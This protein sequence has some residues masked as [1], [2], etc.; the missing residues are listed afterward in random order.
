MTAETRTEEGAAILEGARL[1]PTTASDTV[2]AT[3]PSTP[4]FARQNT[5][6]SPTQM[7]TP[8]TRNLRGLTLPSPISPST[9][10]STVQPNQFQS[11]GEG[12]ASLVAQAPITPVRPA[13]PNTPLLSNPSTASPLPATSP[14]GK[15]S[16][17]GKLKSLLP[18]SHHQ[19]HSYFHAKVEIEQLASVPFVR[20]EFGVRWKFK[21]SVSPGDIKSDRHTPP[22]DEGSAGGL[23]GKMK[24]RSMTG[25]GKGKEDSHGSGEFGMYQTSSNS[26]SPHLVSEGSRS[27][28]LNSFS[29]Y[30]SADSVPSRTSSTA[31][32]NTGYTTVSTTTNGSNKTVAPNGNL[33]RNF[34]SPR[35][36]EVSP[37]KLGANQYLYSHSEDTEDSALFSP[38]QQQAFSSNAADPLSPGWEG[39][40]SPNVLSPTGTITPANASSHPATHGAVSPRNLAYITPPS[41]SPS[42]GLVPYRP[43]KDHS[44]TYS[45]PLNAIVK[46]DIARSGGSG[47]D[48]K[49]RPNLQASE[50]KLVVIQRVIPD[51][52]DGPPQNPRLGAIYLNL[53]EYVGKGRVERRY[54]LKESRLSIELTYVSGNSEYVAPPLPKAEIMGGIENFLVQNEN[55]NKQRTKD[56]YGYT[57][58]P[59][60][61]KEE[62]EVDLLGQANADLLE[63][64]VPIDAG[65]LKAA[66]SRDPYAIP[67]ESESEMDVQGSEAATTTT[68]IDQ[69]RRMFLK[70]LGKSPTMS[71]DKAQQTKGTVT[72]KEAEKLRRRQIKREE[73]QRRF[74][75]ELD[76]NPYALPPSSG[77]S[78]TESEPEEKEESE[79][80]DGFESAPEDDDGGKVDTASIQHTDESHS[81]AGHSSGHDHQR[82]Y[83]PR[84]TNP[85]VSLA[86]F[87]TFDIQRLPLAYGPKTTEVLIDAIFN[88]TLTTDKSKENPFTLYISPGDLARMKDDERRALMENHGGPARVLARTAAPSMRSNG[89]SYS[90]ATSNSTTTTSDSGRSHETDDHLE[91]LRSPDTIVGQPVRRQSPTGLGLAGVPLNRDRDATIDGTADR[92]PQQGGVGGLLQSFQKH[93]KDKVHEGKKR[94]VPKRSDTKRSGSSAASHSPNSMNVLGSP[95]FVQE[96]AGMDSEDVGYGTLRRSGDSNFSNMRANNSSSASLSSTSHGSRSG[97]GHGAPLPPLPVNASGRATPTSRP[98][99]RQN[100]TAS[101]DLSVPDGRMDRTGFVKGSHGGGSASPVPAPGLGNSFNRWW[102]GLGGAHGSSPGA[103]HHKAAPTAVAS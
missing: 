51:D 43:L 15:A 83:R 89:R 66:V 102:K 99:T 29:S 49:P 7:A 45:F 26:S 4:P 22:A 72:S 58:G 96:P 37:S 53:A 12:A 14:S 84:G 27:T 13:T 20:G 46:F 65:G 6:P 61:D 41:L 1:P 57:Y 71:S 97:H 3:K 52:P 38:N 10:S 54:L 68:G 74:R 76:K 101:N 44:I 94:G 60:R 55:L 69:S 85:D 36:G 62:L 2:L 91:G 24:V 18:R 30:S 48:G 67:S 16:T 75:L 70:S 21:S 63:D 33:S 98:L 50:L 73:R 34:F 77:E 17:K 35:A 80:E 100:T 86:S 79:E 28:T 39:A 87:A 9:S 82:H 31:T 92:P 5:V 88:P 78:A 42:K 47:P 81:S 93:R 32:T 19:S 11:L 56:I 40:M 64:D 103:N 23:L 8:K 95:V 59:Y 90:H 25:K